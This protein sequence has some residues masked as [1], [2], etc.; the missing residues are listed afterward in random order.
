M[1][2]LLQPTPTNDGVQPGG[3][4]V[5]TSD[6]WTGTTWLVYGG[7]ANLKPP[8]QVGQ[9]TLTAVTNP[10]NG[11]T[12]YYTVAFTQGNMPACW[13]GLLLYPR[14][15]VAF[16]PPVPLLPPYSSKTDA[17]WS[18]AAAAALG[19][20]NVTM[21]RLEGDIYPGSNAESITLIRVDN[22]TTQ[23]G[24]LLAM[25]LS[26]SVQSGGA[27]PFDDGTGYGGH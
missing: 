4:R 6:P 11:E 8:D 18:A 10:D 23:G 17:L 19:E 14:G 20:L 15:N 12:A 22:A 5:T 7:N 16:P 24:P 1:Y 3:G 2:Q 9:F 25:Q 21:D 13:A 26:S 27:Q